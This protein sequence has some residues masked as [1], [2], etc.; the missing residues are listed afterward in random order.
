MIS[1]LQLHECLDY[2]PKSPGCLCVPVNSISHSMDAPSKH[3]AVC[4]GLLKS[5][6]CS[7]SLP[8]CGFF[9]FPPFIPTPGL[10]P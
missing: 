5:T 7:R 3:K 2:R 4:L 9:C 8:L 10:A 1:L 6:V